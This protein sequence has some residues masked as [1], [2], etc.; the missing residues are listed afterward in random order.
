MRVKRKRK[1][2]KPRSV[3]AEQSQHRHYSKYLTSSGVHWN[4][5][6][7]RTSC[8]SQLQLN[9]LSYP[10]KNLCSL[11]LQFPFYPLLKFWS[12]P[13][14]HVGP[15]S[16]HSLPLF[17]KT[18]QYKPSTLITSSTKT[19]LCSLLYLLTKDCY[20]LMVQI[21]RYWVH[22]LSFTINCLASR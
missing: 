8:S 10:F 13:I 11:F 18:R 1:K 21:I 22:K 17:S 2:I 15:C 14:G 5:S 3:T 6:L 4:L 16:A 9:T 19:S 20:P 12:L 7:L